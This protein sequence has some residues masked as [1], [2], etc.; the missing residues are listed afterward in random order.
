VS[1]TD[2]HS[3]AEVAEL[4]T[5]PDELARAEAENGLRQ[6]DLVKQMVLD[7]LDPQKPFKLRPSMMLALHRAALQGISS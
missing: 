1:P 7:R 2:R 5:D 4:I 6:F 3:Q